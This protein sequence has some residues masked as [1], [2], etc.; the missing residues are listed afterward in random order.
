MKKFN[1]YEYKRPDIEKVSQTFDRL[2]SDFKNADSENEQS[3]IIEEV[4]KLRSNFETMSVLVSIRYTINTN[5]EFYSS[6]MEYIDEV[7]P[8]YDVKEIEFYK[9]L[10]SS[11][12]KDQLKMKI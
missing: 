6:E 4:N 12:F 9:A 5:D 8:L 3:R 11:K 1:D 2:I 10:I 7:E